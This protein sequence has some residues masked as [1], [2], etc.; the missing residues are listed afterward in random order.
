L[1]I[2]YLFVYLAIILNYKIFF[3]FFFFFFFFSSIR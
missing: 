3:F 2:L 1:K